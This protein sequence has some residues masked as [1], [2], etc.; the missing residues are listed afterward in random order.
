MTARLASLTVA[1][2][3]S[4]EPCCIQSSA[5]LRH[6]HRLMMTR[7]VRHLPVLE[8]QRLV[9]L[10]SERDLYLLETLRGVDQDKEPV[11]EAMTDPP[12]TVPPQMVVRDVVR[13]MRRGRYGSAVVVQ[14]GRVLGIFTR[15]DAMRVLEY[16]AE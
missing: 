10:V 14:G 5:T 7:R 2:A 3:M 8:A 12:F 15:T 6:A 9:G 4:K 1:D 13:E 16:L 11:S